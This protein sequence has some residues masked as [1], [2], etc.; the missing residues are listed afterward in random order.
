MAE[1]EKKVVFLDRDGTINVD[2][3]YVHRVEDWVFTERSVEALQLL[4]EAGYVLSVV[5]NQGG[6]GE[7]LYN[8]EDMRRVNE[9]MFAEL[10]RGGVKIEFLAFCPHKI[11]D[12]CKCRKPEVGMIKQVEAQIGPIDYANSWTIG[13]KMKDVELGFNASTRTVLIRS[14]Y[15]SDNDLM[16]LKKKPDLVVG[17]LYEAAKKIGNSGVSS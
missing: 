15:W 5:T 7:G 10:N 13:D 12:K 2:F 4:Q 8:E 14:R 6:V 3:G 1:N 16:G 9:H 11:K 17:S